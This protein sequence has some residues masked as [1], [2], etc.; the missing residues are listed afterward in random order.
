MDHYLP[1]ILANQALAVAAHILE[2]RFAGA[3]FAFVAGSIMRGQGTVGSDIDMVVI[4]P[5]LERAWRES[6]VEEGFPVEAFVHDPATLDVFLGRDVENG[7]PVL[8]N[9]VAEGR[10]VGAQ[11]EG[12]AALR[13]RAAGLL[14]AGPLPLEGERLDLLLYQ[15]SDLA[16]DLRGRRNGEEVLAIAVT[17]YPR[18]VDLMLWGRGQWS[19][20]G[21][22]LPR[23][24]RAVDAALADQ[25]SSAMAR[26][27][28]GDG[29]AM[30]ALC[31]RALAARGGALFAGFRR[32][33]DVAGLGAR[34][35]GN[36]QS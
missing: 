34:F 14:K 11:I 2:T 20:A 13:A 25:F 8:I 18:L 4:Y 24:L 32:E 5:Q 22:W 36:L 10:V 1:G 7:R 27:A 9:M 17:L 35:V 30:L 15:V 28:A 29:A 12:A 33:S 6:L 16:E 19:G 26:A 3:H 21:K 31:E 23:R